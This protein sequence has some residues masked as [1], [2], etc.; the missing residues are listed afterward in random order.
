MCVCN[1]K[2]VLGETVVTNVALTCNSTV[3]HYPSSTL[4]KEYFYINMVT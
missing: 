4:N 2:V 3:S 1:K